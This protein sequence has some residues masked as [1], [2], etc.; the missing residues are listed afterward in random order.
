MERQTRTQRYSDLRNQL[1]NNNEIEGKTPALSTYEEK[2]KNVEEV[3]N[4]QVGVEEAVEIEQETVIPETTVEEVTPLEEELPN[5]TTEAE[6]TFSPEVNVPV[7]EEVTPLEEVSTSEDDGLLDLL[8][9]ISEGETFQEDSKVEETPVEV[10]EVEPET[11]ENEEAVVEEEVSPL[12]TIES[13]EITSNEEPEVAEEP[14]DAIEETAAVQTTPVIEEV[15]VEEPIVEETPIT[16]EAEPVVAEEEPVAV[17]A[18]EEVAPV[19]EVKATSGDDY[20][21]KCLEEVNEYNKAQGLLTADDVPNRILGEVRGIANEEVK[22]EE[23]VVEETI[24]QEELNNTVTLE[25][26][27]ILESMD[28]EAEEQTTEVHEVKAISAPE[29]VSEPAASDADLAKLFETA[30]ISKEAAELL[31]P[32]LKAESTKLDEPVAEEA[33]SVEPISAEEKE[34]QTAQIEAEIEKTKVDIL[35]ANPEGVT[36]EEKLLNDTIPFV[37]DTQ[38]MK[39]ETE[40]EEEDSTPNKVLNIILIVL[41]IILLAVL[42][43]IVYWILMAQ[44]IL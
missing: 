1:E 7:V 30:G 31:R 12:T 29:E 13:E 4:P 38:E 42:C 20:L 16:A 36:S 6:E 25:I 24:S 23:P 9:M 35:V 34:L 39:T 3:L 33:I 18:I 26:K 15:E 32:Y 11:P 41:I 21:E 40:D 5:V 44:G 22:V 37:V 27:K 10:T 17:E 8:E 19:E 14:V 43:V 2:L 28:G